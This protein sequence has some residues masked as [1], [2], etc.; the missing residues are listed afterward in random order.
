M[1]RL[2]I[3]A[4][5]LSGT[6]VNACLNGGGRTSGSH[7]S[8]IARP[9]LPG[10]GGKVCVY[11]SVAG[12]DSMPSSKAAKSHRRLAYASNPPCAYFMPSTASSAN[13]LEIELRIRKL[14]DHGE[15][16]LVMQQAGN[17]SDFASTQPIFLITNMISPS[18]MTVDGRIR[19]K[20]AIKRGI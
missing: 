12:S 1:M 6:R 2:R 9:T 14:R 17:H 15:V 8:T 18:W 7:S 20:N 16:G 11:Q 10:V 4:A 5:A 19:R 13:I 3:L